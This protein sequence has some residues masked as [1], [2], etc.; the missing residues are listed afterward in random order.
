MTIQ[1]IAEEY[2]VHYQTAC[3]AYRKAMTLLKKPGQSP[4]IEVEVWTDVEATMR[5]DIERILITKRM[6]T[7]GVRKTMKVEWKQIWE[8]AL[9]NCTEEEFDMVAAGYAAVANRNRDWLLRP[10]GRYGRVGDRLAHYTQKLAFETTE[11]GD[12]TGFTRWLIDCGFD[13]EMGAGDASEDEP[14]R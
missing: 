5:Q 8:D 6:V 7:T 3:R 2:G 10:M 4:G 12:Y 1:K 13:A 9:E 11:K 14:R